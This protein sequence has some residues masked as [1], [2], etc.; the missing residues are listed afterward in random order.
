MKQENMEY[1]KEVQQDLTFNFTGRVKDIDNNII[2]AALNRDGRR[3]CYDTCMQI[4]SLMQE[5]QVI[6]KKFD[7]TLFILKSLKLRDMRILLEIFY[8]KK[9]YEYLQEKYNLSLISII[10]NLR[11]ATGRYYKI[12]K[13]VINET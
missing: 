2:K 13:E 11:R 1:Y 6:I 5:K 12:K 8:R 4:L 3:S 7:D 9:S 10:R